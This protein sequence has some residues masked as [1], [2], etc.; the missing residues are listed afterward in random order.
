MNFTSNLMLWGCMLW[1][2]WLMY[3]LL[4]NEAKPKKNII[5]GT[6]L[7]YEAH[8]DPQVQEILATFRRE[9]KGICWLCML[10]AVPCV[11]IRSFGLSMTLWLTWVVVVCMVP[12]VPYVRCNRALRALKEARGWKRKDNARAVADLKAA[13]A[14]MKWLSPVLFLPPVLISLVPVFFERELWALWLV[15]ALMVALFYICYRYLYRNRAEMVDDDTERTMALTRIRRYNWGKA[16]L[17]MAWATGIL[18]PLI[19]L[20]LDH[21]WWNVVV[22]L[23]YMA[24]VM[25][26]ALSIEFRV[27]SLQEKLCEGSGRD[28]YVDEDDCWI[29]GMFYYN[30]N[31]KRLLV[32]ARVGINSTI[33]LARRSGQILAGATLLL[34]L[35]CPLMGIWLMDMEKAPVELT[36]T[37]TELVAEHYTSEYTVALE[38]IASIHRLE[39]LPAIRRVTGT[40]MPNVSTGI[41]TCDDWGRLTCCVDPRTGPWLLVETEDGKQYLFNSTD[42]EETRAVFEQIKP[43]LQ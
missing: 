16:W 22:F 20:T 7:P 9:L 12:M 29:W 25:W 8:G 2:P 21:F 14:E 34:L 3:V 39:E 13:A 26:A 28:Y 43:A 30:P 11:F 23:V 10:P 36:V 5:V 31:D 41:W 35:A 37:E 17:V 4:K 6:T 1:M 18:N 33:N 19:W 42:P 27:R 40:G 38:D 32:N 24:V 15:M